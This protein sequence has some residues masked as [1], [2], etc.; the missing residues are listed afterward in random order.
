M[1]SPSTGHATLAHLD[2]PI[3]ERAKVQVGANNKKLR[4]LDEDRE[5]HKERIKVLTENLANNANC[6]PLDEEGL[7]RLVNQLYKLKHFG[8]NLRAVK[9][10]VATT[11]QATYREGHKG[12]KG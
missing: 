11:H 2:F 6:R 12:L 4:A 5:K 7:N 8:E 10:T 9:Q 1:T 3:K